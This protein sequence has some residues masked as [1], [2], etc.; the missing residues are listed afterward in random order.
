MAIYYY[1]EFKKASKK[2]LVVC[3]C[4][5]TSLENESQQKEKDIV[6]TIYYLTGYVFETILKFSLYASIGFDK[7]VNIEKLNSHNLTFKKDIKTHSLV[8]LKRDVEAKS[9]TSF[10]QYENNKDLFS[11]WNSKIRYDEKTKFSKEEVLSFF[12]FSKDIYTTLQQY[13]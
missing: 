2:H 10:P 4:L 6:T 11:S 1:P 13:K 5:I 7:K 9:I 3:E 8:K 12:T